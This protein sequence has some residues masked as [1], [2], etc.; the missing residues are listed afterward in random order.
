MA[1]VGEDTRQGVLPE[2]SSAERPFS[3]LDSATIAARRWRKRTAVTR[4]RVRRIPRDTSAKE[5]GRRGGLV[6]I[7]AETSSDK[8][9]PNGNA[10]GWNDVPQATRRATKERKNRR[11]GGGN[12]GVREDGLRA[13]M[14]I[15]DTGQSPL[16]RVGGQ[17]EQSGSHVVC[18]RTVNTLA[19]ILSGSPQATLKADPAATAA[20]MAKRRNMARFEGVEL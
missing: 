2:E 13:C 15:P 14:V 9:S 3:I 12:A 17:G 6:G 20:S 7:R 19:T 8:T 5:A 16:M 4:A 1:W 11:K 10:G 18:K